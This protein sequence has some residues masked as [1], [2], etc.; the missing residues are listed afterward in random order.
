MNGFMARA[1]KGEDLQFD[2]P[3]ETISNTISFQSSKQT[4]TR[5][6]DVYAESFKD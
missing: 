5:V 6:A 1:K 3:P 4:E 2:S